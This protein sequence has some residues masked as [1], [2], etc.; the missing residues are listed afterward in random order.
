MNK[1]LTLSYSKQSTNLN[2]DQSTNQIDSPI[3]QFLEK[4]KKRNIFYIG[5]RVVAV[6]IQLK[7]A[8]YLIEVNEYG[9]KW[10]MRI[11]FSQLIK[12]KKNLCK[13][14]QIKLT[15]S[16]NFVFNQLSPDNMKKRAQKIQSFLNQIGVQIIKILKEFYDSEFFLLLIVF[17]RVK[18]FGKNLDRLHRRRKP[19][20][21]IL[22]RH[23]MIM[24]CILNN[25]LSFLII[26]Y[27][28]EISILLEQNYCQSISANNFKHVLIQIKS[29]IVKLLESIKD[30]ILFKQI[31]QIFKEISPEN[32]NITNNNQNRSL[33]AFNQYK[34]TSRQLLNYLIQGDKHKTT[35]KIIN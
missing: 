34:N 11:R 22:N 26:S 28:F 16:S 27:Y 3:L 19:L 18:M 17:I 33:T 15:L 2:L 4:Q 13:K 21:I 7:H 31:I 8:Y 24:Q 5:F 9:K 12:F 35:S 32:R 23:N 14:Y 6:Q 25:F 1:G 20:I 10:I 30:I 29:K